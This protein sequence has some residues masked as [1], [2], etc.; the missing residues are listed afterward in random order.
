MSDL[1]NAPQPL[2]LAVFVSGSG[3]NL[4]ALIDATEAGQL[5]GIEIA[6]VI[7]NRPGAQGL[8]RA[9]NHKLPAIYLPWKNREEAERRATALIDLFHID[10]IVLAGWM[11][12][13]N[14]DFTAQYPQRMIN[15]HPA[16]LPDNAEETYTTSDGS[17][18]PALRGLHVVQ[19]AIDAG[20]KITGSTVHYVIPEVDA[21]PVLLRSEVA[22]EPDDDEERLQTRI[23]EHE[24]LLV[25]EAVRKYQYQLDTKKK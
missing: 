4:Q 13:F 11:R 20:L 17:V 21:G 24:H 18:I 7:C 22:I 6:L 19:R 5:P 23:K 12:I 15:L 9:L 10:L 3:S 25:V 14:P 16:L 1:V 2:R 8:Q